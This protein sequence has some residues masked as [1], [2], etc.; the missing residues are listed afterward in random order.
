MFT[1]IELYLGS[2]SDLIYKMMSINVNV[3]ALN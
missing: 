3:I 1:K 2:K